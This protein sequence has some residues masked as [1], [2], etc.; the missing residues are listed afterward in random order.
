[1]TRLDSERAFIAANFFL[2]DLADRTHNDELKVFHAMSGYVPG[3]G[4]GDPAMWYDWLARVRKVQ[5]GRL[6]PDNSGERG[7]LSAEMM[8]PL[9]AEQ[10]YIATFEYLEEYWIRVNRPPELSDILGAM[11]YTP[12]VGTA[13]PS[14]WNAW[15]AAFEKAG[16]A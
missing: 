1:M 14:L 8:Q 12:G 16:Q 7:A 3:V 9:D 13:E 11:R 6:I 15:L 4:S 5:T 10:A 2:R